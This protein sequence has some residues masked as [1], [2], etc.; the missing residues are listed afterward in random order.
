M[1]ETERA[2]QIEEKLRDFVGSFLFL[3]VRKLQR[4]ERPEGRETVIPAGHWDLVSET[5]MEVEE[6][7]S[8]LLKCPPSFFLMSFVGE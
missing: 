8:L 6:K 7:V 2:K 3:P 4:I 5:V 1:I